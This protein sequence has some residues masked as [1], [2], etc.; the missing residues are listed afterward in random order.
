VCSVFVLVRIRGDTESLQDASDA[1]VYDILGHLAPEAQRRDFMS[2][3]PHQYE[4]GVVCHSFFVLIRVW[5]SAEPLQ[6]AS[7]LL[8]FTLLV[9]LAPRSAKGD[10]RISCPLARTKTRAEHLVCSVFVLVRIRGDA[11]SLQDASML[12]VFNSVGA[13]CPRSAAEGFHVLL[14]AP[15]TEKE[16]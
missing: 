9:H 14:P 13:S 11:E 2:S 1:L 5:G 16:S 12:L 7:K 4:K 3:C 10:A 6:D 15:K 8:V